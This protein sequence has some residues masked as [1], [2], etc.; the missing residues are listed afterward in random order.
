[1][2]NLLA[3]LCTSF[4]KIANLFYI[5]ISSKTAYHYQSNLMHIYTEESPLHSIQAL[6]CSLQLHFNIRETGEK[7]TRKDAIYSIN[8]LKISMDQINAIKMHKLLKNNV[9][10]ILAYVSNIVSFF[11][12]IFLQKG[13]FTFLS[14]A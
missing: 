10:T 4:R 8:I 14:P 7:H 6:V 1:M 12:Q 3:M 13:L 11:N 9:R 2:N 5:N